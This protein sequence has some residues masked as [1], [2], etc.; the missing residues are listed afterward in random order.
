[1]TP[2]FFKEVNY[3]DSSNF[4]EEFK[5]ILKQYKLVHFKGVPAHLDYK[6]YY[7]TLVDAIGE[8][9]NVDED[10]KT[11]NEVSTERW[12]DVR[13][14]KENDYTFRHANTR[15][16][17]HTDAAY[18]NFDQDINFFFCMENA[19][20]GGATVFIDSD[21]LLAILEKFEPQLLTQLLNTEV[22]F[23]KGVDQRKTRKIIDK[24]AKGNKVNWNYYRIMPD[25]PEDVKQMCEAFHAFLENKIVGGGLLTAINLKPGESAIFHDDRVLHGRN[26][27][28]GSRNLIKGGFNYK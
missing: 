26:S 4:N 10:I 23:G 15:Q 7:G 20:V 16:P 8:V 27:F 17:L 19:E 18:T 28:Y 2:L 1:M 13:Y 14:E 25:N 22:A 21:H 11:G 6:E 3:S 9:L 5:A 12:T 24:D